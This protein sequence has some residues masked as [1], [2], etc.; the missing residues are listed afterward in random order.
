M[1]CCGWIFVRACYFGDEN[2]E[3][4]K[5]RGRASDVCA[6][7]ACHRGGNR[8]DRCE[9][10]LLEIAFSPAPTWLV[11]GARLITRPANKREGLVKSEGSTCE[12]GDLRSMMK[13]A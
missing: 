13:S 9:L 2:P 4:Q 3:E 11:G 10:G 5:L 7:S 6:A 1:Y 12:D 8:W